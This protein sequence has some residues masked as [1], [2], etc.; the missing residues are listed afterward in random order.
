MITPKNLFVGSVRYDLN[1]QEWVNITAELQHQMYCWTVS[2]MLSQEKDDQTNLMLMFYLNTQP[3]GATST[4]QKSA[5][6]HF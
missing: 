1:N 3:Q 6:K 5:L 2:L 4:L